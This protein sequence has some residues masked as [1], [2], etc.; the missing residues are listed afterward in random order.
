M[1]DAGG[2]TL[3]DRD[4]ELAA[5]GD[6]IQ[7]AATGNGRVVVVD[8]PAGIGKTELL[9]ATRDLA[10]GAGMTVLAGRGREL[11]HEFA[12]GVVRQ[13]L[14]PD[15]RPATPTRRAAL[16]DGAAAL[17]EPLLGAASALTA[18]SAAANPD[19]GFGLVHGL[20]WLTA[21]LAEENPVLI[22]VDDVHWA[23]PPTLR[24]L[25]YLGVRCAELPVLLVVGVRGGEPRDAHELLVAVDAEPATLRL[26]PGS[27]SGPSVTEIVAA[28]LGPEPDPGFCGACARASGGNPFLLGELIAELA[29]ERIEPVPGAVEHVERVR[30]A[31]VSRSVLLRMLRLGHDVQW[32]ARAVAV[33]EKCELR[34][35]AALA[36]LEPEAARVA[37]DRLYEAQILTAGPELSFL[38]PLLRHTVYDTIPPAARSD[39]HRRA[40]LLLAGRGVGGSALGAHLLRGEATGDPWVVQLCRETAADARAAGAPAG[41]ARLLSRALAE[42][43]EGQSRIEVL[44]ELGE[45]EA[46]SRA[47]EAGEHL[48]AALAGE[49]PPLRRVTLVSALAAWLVW[50]GHP[51]DAY[52]CVGEALDALG[53]SLAVELRAALETIRMAIASISREHIAIVEERLDE[54]HEL[55]RAA[56]RA[57][58]ALF[59]TEGCVRAQRQPWDGPWRE[60]V[61]TGLGDGAFVSAQ[62]GFSPVVDYAAVVFIHGDEVARSERLLG[63]MRADAIA[64]GSIRGHLNAVAWNAVLALR[65]GDLARAEDDARTARELALR[66]GVVFTALWAGAVLTQ[67]LTDQGRYEAA[68]AVLSR[69]D[70]DPARGSSQWLHATLARARLLIASGR[71]AEAV[72]PLREV[73]ELT[74][75]DNPSYVPWRSTLA[76]ALGPGLEAAQVADDEL[77]RARQLGQPRGIAGAL[78]AVAAAGQSDEPV[79]VLA[80]AVA[81][82]RESPARLELA[83][84]L[85]DLGAAQRR[86]GERMAAREPLREAAEL[87]RACGAAP[88][89]ARAR[90]ELMATG[91]RPRRARFAGAEAL[92]PSELRVAELAASGLTNREIAQSLFVTAKTVGTHLGHIYAKLGLRGAEAREQLGAALRERAADPD[93]AAP[94]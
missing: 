37:A 27:L 69:A 56:G 28:R 21:N 4:A 61:E 16:L 32:L 83:R 38:H 65:R 5:L 62:S 63:E 77:A 49:L 58:A 36:E 70:L 1:G 89:A 23:D 20:Y 11:E 75:I 41:A 14:E 71:A 51:G 74:I 78:R 94:A 45:V 93:T 6:A 48:S 86:R 52:A 68:D 22:V 9:R 53:E 88:L 67:A 82:L 13:L 92:T 73:G 10:L 31:S 29:E 25:A 15:L 40:A 54:L 76:A 55:A 39:G 3:L 2:P 57:G 79:V 81:L 90:D 12:F 8:G 30:P 43:A 19:V 33:L 87:A 50:N 47:P 42:P 46:L 72:A 34:D 18:A 84:A 60:L 26:A 66:H 17:A 7:A 64:R 80:E 85:C 24:F 91:A 59:I 44:G 35:A